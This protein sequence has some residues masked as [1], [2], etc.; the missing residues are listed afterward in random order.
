M[1]LNYTTDTPVEKTIVEI[2][3]LLAGHNVSA[4]MT[5]YEGPQV[6]ALNF[7]IKINDKPM[8]FRLPCN[9][10]AVQQI[11]KIKNANRKRRNGRLED[12][13]KDSDEQAQRVAWRIIKDWVEAQLAL[14]E[15]NMVTVPQ[16]FLPYTIMKD[17]RTLSEHAAADPNFLLGDGK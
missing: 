6:S 8:G 15:V 17:G 11:F 7:Q 12:K 2:Q 4:I 10:R 3:G 9:W 1:L 5:E 16:V 13:I 14:V